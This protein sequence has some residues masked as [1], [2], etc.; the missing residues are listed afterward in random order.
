[1]RSPH[2]YRGALFQGR[3]QTGYLGLSKKRRCLR[4]IFPRIHSEGPSRVGYA[5]APEVFTRTN[6]FHFGEYANYKNA[7]DLGTCGGEDIRGTALI[8][9]FHLKR[10]LVKLI[11]EHSPRGILNQYD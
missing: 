1:M 8:I 5:C 3:R 7:V 9:F 10:R 2:E 6:V 11:G 4:L